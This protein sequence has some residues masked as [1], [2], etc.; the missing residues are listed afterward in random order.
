MTGNLRKINQATLKRPPDVSIKV[1]MIVGLLCVNSNLVYSDL[2][3][4]QVYCELVNWF[5]NCY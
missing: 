2:S 5:C 1:R 3:D 4:I